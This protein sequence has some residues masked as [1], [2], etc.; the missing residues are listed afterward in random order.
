MNWIA[1]LLSI[2]AGIMPINGWI[3]NSDGSAFSEPAY[4]T[5]VESAVLFFDHLYV[6]GTTETYMFR[7]D[8]TFRPV[9][10]TYTFKTALQWK[11]IEVGFKHTCGPHPIY[12]YPSIKSSPP[13]APFEGATQKV[14][15]KFSATIE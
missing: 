2:E 6:G 11:K 5:T 15:I 4:Y 10:A 8:V 3:D 7:G 9:Q 13:R 1:L 12:T 14:Y